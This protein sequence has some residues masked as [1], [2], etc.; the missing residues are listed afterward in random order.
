MT[1]LVVILI[2]MHSQSQPDRTNV[3]ESIRACVVPECRASWRLEAIDSNRKFI[4]LLP[5]EI[6]LYAKLSSAS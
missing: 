5:E 6:S 2:A 1:M 4:L 3:P